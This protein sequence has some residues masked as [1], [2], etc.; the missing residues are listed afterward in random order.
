MCN[1]QATKGENTT[2][3]LMTMVERAAAS[4]RKLNTMIEGITL[5]E[6]V[7]SIS[8]SCLTSWDNGD[9]N[10]E[11]W[12]ITWKDKIVNS[13]DCKITVGHQREIAK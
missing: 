5:R 13:S 9:A 7:G 4:K 6:D 3:A 2:T 1:N 10:F 11:S 8:V 12:R